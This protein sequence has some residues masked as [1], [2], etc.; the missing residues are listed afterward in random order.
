[1]ENHM[2]ANKQ[3]RST[4]QASA[5]QLLP[6]IQAIGSEWNAATPRR[7]WGVGVWRRRMIPA[8][9]LL[10]ATLISGVATSS[11]VVPGPLIAPTSALGPNA[12][13][14]SAASNSSANAN[15][16]SVLKAPK[17]DGRLHL[18]LASPKGQLRLVTKST[19]LRW[20][21]DRPIIAL[22]T[23]D[24]RTNAAQGATQ[25]TVA[26]LANADPRKYV[27]IE[28][29]IEGS[30]RWSST[31]VLVFTPARK[32]PLS[33]HFD[34]KL[35]GVKALDGTTLAAPVESSFDTPRVNCTQY[36]TD[37]AWNR[38][39]ASGAVLVTCDQEVDGADLAAH[40]TFAVQSQVDDLANY[41][42]PAA[43]LAAMRLADPK[44]TALLESRLAELSS[45]TVSERSATLAKSGP[46]PD[47]GARK[48]TCHWLSLGSATGADAGTRTANSADLP[49][50]ADVQLRFSDGI[51]SKAGKLTSLFI[52]P[53]SV[54]TPTALL[55]GIDCTKECDPEGGLNLSLRSDVSA[56]D[57]DGKIS[58]TAVDQAG[59]LGTRTTYRYKSDDDSPLSLGWAAVVPGAT[60][61]LELDPSIT[62]LNGRQLGY[63]YIATVSFGHRSAYV[64]LPSGEF[65][66]ALSSRPLTIPVRNV[67]AIDQVVREL[68]VETLQ[69]TLLDAQ[70]PEASALLKLDRDAKELALPQA[71]QSLDASFDFPI[72]LPGGPNSTGTYLVAIRGK[73]FAPQSTYGSAPS[74]QV[75]IIQRG[76]RGITIKR[77]PTD[78]LV[79]VTSL[80]S[81]KPGI[82]GGA[83]IAPVSGANDQVRVGVLPFVAE[84]QDPSAPAILP[85]LL[86]ASSLR[87]ERTDANGFVKTS[88]PLCTEAKVTT[89][90]DGAARASG[91]N[92]AVETKRAPFPAGSQ[93]CELVAMVTAADGSALAY[94]RSSWTLGGRPMPFE[95]GVRAME[96]SGDESVTEEAG[97]PQAGQAG[98]PVA[99]PAMPTL[100]LGER[101][102]GALFTDRGV[103]KAGEEV[104]VRGNLR[105]EFPRGVKLLAPNLLPNVG[106][107][108]T[109]DAGGEVWR[110]VVAVD[111]GQARGGFDAVFTLPADARQGN[112]TIAVLDGLVSTSFL[113]T[114][115]RRPDFKVDV[116]VDR[117]AYVPGETITGSSAGTY[118]FGAPMA[119]LEGRWVATASPTSFDPTDGHPELGLRNFSWTYVCIWYE[120]CDD[121]NEEGAI[122]TVN[123]KLDADGKQV[124]RVALPVN[125]KR[126]SPSNVTV[127]GIVTNVD[128][129]VIANRATT[130]VHVGEYSLGVKSSTYFGS[131]GKPI[132]AQVAALKADGTW[133]SGVSVK[134]SLVRWDWPQDPDSQ[135][136][137]VPKATVISTGSV[138]TSTAAT[139][140]SFT[141]NGPGTY[142]LRVESTDARGNYIEAGTTTYVLGKGA[143]FGQPDS[144]SLELSASAQTYA[145]GDQAQVLVKSPWPV[146]EGIVT[147]ERDDIMSYARISLTGGAAALTI[148]ISAESLPNVH[149][150]VMLFRLS[151]A[152]PETP[153][154]AAQE[155]RPEVLTS[156]ISLQVPPVSRKLGVKVTTD[157]PTYRPGSAATAT[158]NVTD[159][160][161]APVDGSVTLWAVDE[162]VL[163]LTG[164][165]VPDLLAQLWPERPNRVQTSESRTR[166][167]SIE[168]AQGRDEKLMRM[169]KRASGADAA[170]LENAAP[171][172]AAPAS[173]FDAAK[174]GSKDGESQ[175][176]TLRTDFRV[177]AHWQGTAALSATGT[178][179]VPMKLPQSLT[180]YRVIAVASSGNDRFGGAS[181]VVEIRQPFMVQPAL[182]RFVAVGDSFEAGAV[183]QNQTGKPG[184]VKLTLEIPND[185]PVSI[186]GPTT[187]TLTLPVG[188]TEV[189]FRLRANRLG[190]WNAQFTATLS[191]GGTGKDESDAVQI[192]VPVLLTHRLETVA[193]AGQ[194]IASAGGAQEV[195]QIV[196]PAG[197]VPDQ[198]GL[199][200]TTA[201][202]ALVGL[203]NGVDYLV[204]YPYGCLE[205]RSSRLRA[206]VMLSDL[207]DQFP[208]PS[209][210]GEKFKQ[211]IIAEMARIR[212]Y[213]TPDGGLGYWEG[214][215]SAD[216]YLSARVLILLLDARDLGI[217]VPNDVITRVTGYLS[218]IVANVKSQSLRRPLRD[219][220]GVWPNRAH[221]LYALARAGVPDTELMAKL[222][223]RRAELPILEQ[224]HLVNA[225]VLGG[226]KGIRANKLYGELLSSV[227]V[228]A[229][230]AFL[231]DETSRE[232]WDRFVC[233]CSAYLGAGNTHNTAEL[234]SL[235]VKADPTNPLAPQMARW[236][237]AQRDKQG[238]WDNTL[239][240]GY[241]LTALV[242]YYRAAEPTA[243][244][245]K[246]EVL[247]GTT[248]AY[249]KV[250]SGRSL[251]AQSTQIPMTKLSAA[252]NGKTA[253][254]S[255]G[256]GSVPLT[257]KATGNGTLF[258]N[259][260]LRYEP[261]TKTLKALDSGFAVER[262][263]LPYVGSSNKTINGV[264]TFAAG[265]LVR[266]SLTI[267]TAQNRRNVVIDDPIPAGLEPLDAR[268]SSTSQVEVSGGEAVRDG[269]WFG[270]DHVE[271]QDNRV[272]LFA[273]GL[274]PGTFTY[275]YVA[276]ATAP[277]TFIAAPTQAEE[278]YRP[279]IFGR[280]ATATMVITP[281]KP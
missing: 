20:V 271:I 97:S 120:R 53:I 216:V 189:R 106:V 261:A 171:V 243:P 81:G 272:L 50:D 215:N 45:A 9:A 11:A 249:E 223:T 76:D 234:L 86:P 269:S 198:G 182:P 3:F 210:A 260:R 174:P 112:Y 77:S 71:T 10:A 65:V 138:T 277:G 122:G 85:A 8:V 186:D 58:L 104:H 229:D 239:E 64:Q 257:V 154:N 34:V 136:S 88:A 163:R 117:P 100:P 177:L 91:S 130:L 132:P 276:R 108:V 46:C 166:A 228:E 127:E 148:P 92:A 168:R 199:E 129:Q 69:Q 188:P 93:N 31:R 75:S 90:V 226:M 157:S 265:D 192:S 125:S 280:T 124:V 17:D 131:A 12:S 218:G 96:A 133:Q 248:S 208:L 235:L 173:N 246:A 28:P 275:T 55:A 109:D 224:L 227:R 151:P 237:M 141:P 175:P 187:Q 233:P 240:N 123:G 7:S 207:R 98:A 172:A 185:S 139:D 153:D 19:E 44:G 144:N 274:E 6:R 70:R 52:Q 54:R 32:L 245:F 203:Q 160:K 47:R 21:F 211:S 143:S 197:V 33:T 51:A 258:W 220:D 193:A 118:L 89:A 230:Q 128:R 116:V 78:V 18:V 253:G 221:V 68:T 111:Q 83:S 5:E 222:W 27:Q 251:A 266:V 62:D 262:S 67:T 255:G 149:V 250:F 94:N 247:L 252:L 95:D 37:T 205:Q 35:S 4:S 110:G 190:T 14:T 184:Q 101:F 107:L 202:S 84:P 225:M 105:V 212:N 150:S 219:V 103:Y 74:W 242:N 43:D 232:A 191:G 57:L 231:Q 113:S 254:A 176:V 213:L 278:M 140:F 25:T 36:G 273:T 180:S 126:H 204:E 114:T 152:V 61:R 29:A 26:A 256:V 167:F 121:Q 178:A 267:R 23:I 179:S 79:A 146:A 270:V 60:Y 59:T 162:G 102:I 194:V 16:Y 13:G 48:I 24:Q 49:L 115:Y 156:L 217:G 181:T 159:T 165:S 145:L 206:L 142:E 22:S 259:A 38:G 268:L 281:P 241:A 80:A 200:L 42:P 30:F 39:R 137:Y 169:K 56:K 73:R 183:L 244:N 214:N 15:P 164:Y 263:Y 2:S 201:S 99:M 279:E 155:P 147:V 158:V 41:Q 40:T 134:T 135:G 1:M 63:R 264:S 195:E 119:G 82:G 196:P 236:L 170:F 161:G 66:S 209:L 87:V 72:Q 238:R